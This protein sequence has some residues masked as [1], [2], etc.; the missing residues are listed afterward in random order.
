MFATRFRLACGCLPALM[1]LAATPAVWAAEAGE[2]FVPLRSTGSYPIQTRD[3]AGTP[4]NMTPNGAMRFGTSYV[5]TAGTLTVDGSALGFSQ[6][7]ISADGLELKG[8]ASL[9]N[10]RIT[11]RVRIDVKSGLCRFVDAFENVG[12]VAMSVN[13]SQRY[14]VSGNAQQMVTDGGTNLPRDSTTTLGKNESGVLIVHNRSGTAEATSLAVFLAAR[15]SAAKPT[16]QNTSYSNIIFTLPLSIEPRRT[17]AVLHGVAP[18]RLT[19]APAGGELARLFIPFSQPDWTRDLP[20]E[21]RTTFVNWRPVR[22]A[23][24]TGRSLLQPVLDLVFD[25]GVERGPRQDVLLIDDQTRLVGQ[26]EGTGLTLRGRFGET[27]VV[28]DEIAALEGREHF[29]RLY[30][31]NGDVLGG[32]VSRCDLVLA[33]EHGVR[34]HLQPHQVRLLMMRA[35][36]NDGAIRAADNNGRAPVIDLIALDLRSGDRLTGRLDDDQ[37]IGMATPW[38]SH[39]VSWKDVGD[40]RIVRDEQPLHRIEFR[41]GSRLR[42]I[43]PPQSLALRDTRFGTVEAATIE[44]AGWQT[45][46]PIPPAASLSNAD[47]AASAEN[48]SSGS[49][50][51]TEVASSST[52]PPPMPEPASNLP[53][54]DESRRQL[55]LALLKSA[56]ESIAKGELDEARQQA[57]VVR[58]LGAKLLPDDDTPERVLRDIPR[59]RTAEPAAA[60]EPSAPAPSTAAAVEA[61]AAEV[62]SDEDAEAEDADDAELSRPG[63]PIQLRLIGGN[64][65]VGRLAEARMAFVTTAGELRIDAAGIAGFQPVEDPERRVENVTLRLKDGRTIQVRPVNARL[66]YQALGRSWQIPWQH[67]LEYSVDAELAPED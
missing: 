36:E 7:A 41:D 1:F 19:A 47:A 2:Q 31:R 67:V 37:R 54:A 11:R 53:A 21:L 10:L 51:G 25:R 22:G 60:G 40:M 35:S 46:S 58:K 34:V 13:V 39:D 33:S 55:A 16:V 9:G 12:G 65:L 38:G 32:A 27:P 59:P 45:V 62:A 4:W 6:L 29:V 24:S 23:G 50:S 30:F 43:L 18:Q 17:A 5:N 15:N 56:R 48:G 64:L 42:T 49:A 52:P 57:E 3:A 8:T 20:A 44:I 28:L 61:T 26:V 66:E 14:T 63:F